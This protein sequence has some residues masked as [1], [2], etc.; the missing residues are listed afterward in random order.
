LPVSSPLLMCR[1]APR[2]PL[3]PYTPLFRSWSR[4]SGG[5]AIVVLTDTGMLSDPL[6]DTF[7]RIEELRVFDLVDVSVAPGGY[8]SDA[9]KSNYDRKSTRLNSSHVSISYAVFCLKKI[10]T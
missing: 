2:S 10:I 4:L 1:P 7:G 8:Y 6:P 3:F 9:T 5:A